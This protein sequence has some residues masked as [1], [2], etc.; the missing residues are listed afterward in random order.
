MTTIEI[1][2]VL[3]EAFSGGDVLC[4]E[5]RL[6]DE[7]IDYVRTAYT[8]TVTDLGERW[9]QLQFKRGLSL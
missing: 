3:S 1:D 7:E 8:A 4:R 5:L 2:R 9:Y 6:T